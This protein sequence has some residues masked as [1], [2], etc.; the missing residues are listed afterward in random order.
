MEE[1]ANGRFELRPVPL[2]SQVLFVEAPGTNPQPFTMDVQPGGILDRQLVVSADDFS[3]IP[4]LR[5]VAK[6]TADK[7]EAGILDELVRI[8]VG[9]EDFEDLRDDL[10][11]A[12][13][14][15]Q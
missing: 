12:L 5:V 9:C 15:I 4:V 2:G 10:D 7:E 6:I 13:N 11:Q 8:A 1:C 14:K 3:D